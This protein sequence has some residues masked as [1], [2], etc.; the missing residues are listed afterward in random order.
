[1]DM[2][3]LFAHSSVDGC[4]YCFYVFHVM[5]NASVNTGVHKFLSCMF[6]FLLHIYLRVEF[7]GHIIIVCLTFWGT[8][9]LFYKAVAPF[10][11][12]T[13]N[14]WGFS[15][16]L[17]IFVIIFFYYSQ[18]SGLIMVLIYISLMSNDV[19]PLFIYLLA[20]CISLEKCLF[21]S[22]LIFCFFFSFKLSF[23]WVIISLY[24][25]FGHNPIR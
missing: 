20:T 19:K 8:A 18:F 21:G 9:K 11:I 6:L 15:A 24:V 2:L 4:L 1:M 22:F 7:L 23:F 10:F 12:P 17:P 25:Y 13:G 5:N 16:S 14:A 3:I